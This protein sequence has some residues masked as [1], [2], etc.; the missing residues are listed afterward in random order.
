MVD[1]FQ[2]KKPIQLIHIICGF[3]QRIDPTSGAAA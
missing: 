1:L 2:R 3:R